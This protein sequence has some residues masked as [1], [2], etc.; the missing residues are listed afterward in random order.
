[1]AIDASE[2]QKVAHLARLSIDDSQVEATAGT[3]NKILDL[4]DQMQ[5]VNTDNVEPMAHPL[6]ATQRL[7]EDVVTEPNNRETL[8][9]CAPAVEDGLFLVPKV[10]E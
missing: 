10:I 4:V 8:Q 2:V 9:S 5:S 3:I 7:R 6:D 1:M